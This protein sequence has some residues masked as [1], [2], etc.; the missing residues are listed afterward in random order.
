MKSI[1]ATTILLNTIALGQIEF[2]IEEPEPDFDKFIKQEK[3]EVEEIKPP[4]KTHHEKC[5][6]DCDCC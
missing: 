2:K 3:I 1:I 5:N 4:C 6:E